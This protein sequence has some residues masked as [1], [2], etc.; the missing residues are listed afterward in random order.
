MSCQIVRY[1]MCR[2][3]FV[4]YFKFKAPAPFRSIW[5]LWV[6][7]EI[8]LFPGRIRMFGPTHVHGYQISDHEWIAAGGGGHS[9]WILAA[10][11]FSSA[12]AEAVAA[13]GHLPSDWAHGKVAKLLGP[14]SN[15]YWQLAASA[16]DSHDPC[17]LK[18]GQVRL[19]NWLTIFKWLMLVLPLPLQS[20]D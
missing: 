6:Y 16:S 9:I 18:R 2:Y 3:C 8:C 17:L 15:D 20:L 1:V 11:N 13:A 7:A 5:Y 4:G 19:P 10:L 12:A 14:G